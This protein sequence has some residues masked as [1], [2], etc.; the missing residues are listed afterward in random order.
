MKIRTKHTFLQL[1]LCQGLGKN[2][3]LGKAKSRMIGPLTPLASLSDSLDLKLSYPQ[4]SDSTKACT[5]SN[6][7]NKQTIV[8]T[9]SNLCTGLESYCKEPLGLFGYN[10]QERLWGTTPFFYRVGMGY[11]PSV[12]REIVEK[13]R[14]KP[15]S[16]LAPS[17]L[18]AGPFFGSKSVTQRLKPCFATQQTSGT[19]FDLNG[20]EPALKKSNKLFIFIKEVKRQK[21]MLKPFLLTPFGSHKKTPMFGRY[22]LQKQSQPYKIP[23]R[24]ACKLFIIYV[25]GSFCWLYLISYSNKKYNSGKLGLLF[26]EVVFENLPLF[27]RNYLFSKKET[28]ENMMLNPSDTVVKN[29]TKD[30]FNG[31]IKCVNIELSPFFRE[32]LTENYIGRR[33]ISQELPKTQPEKINPQKSFLPVKFK[34]QLEAFLGTRKEDSFKT[35]LNSNSLSNEDFLNK[36]TPSFELVFF[37]RKPLWLIGGSNSKTQK[38]AFWK[39]DKLS[40]R[41]QYN[42]S[43]TSMIMTPEIDFLPRKLEN[44]DKTVGFITPEE[45][46]NCSSSFKTINFKPQLVETEQLQWFETLNHTKFFSLKNSKWSLKDQPANLVPF[47]ETQESYGSNIVRDKKE[48]T[49]EK[50]N[51]NL[52]FFNLSTKKEENVCEKPSFLKTKKNATK[53]F[54][55]RYFY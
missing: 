7:N 51:L 41:E 36:T 9:D 1:S 53:P 50:K 27:Q 49:N 52:K 43:G 14:T 48:Q 21:E 5:S 25:V 35:V 31:E 15:I 20:T 6:G 54:F 23:I 29:D 19:S 22:R 8:S 3:P 18:I 13:I 4:E 2:S 34:T 11:R 42:Y 26:Q 55:Y 33:I 45:K 30:L 37:S 10:A 16:Y 28:V 40:Q 44:L 47:F 24:N 39:E 17:A 32:Y 38:T 12:K 46:D